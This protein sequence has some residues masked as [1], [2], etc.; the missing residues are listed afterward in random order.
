MP[1]KPLTASELVAL[2][3][4]AVE[5]RYDVILRLL[6]RH[7][8][9]QLRLY[10]TRS[11]NPIVAF[12]DGVVPAS[13]VLSCDLTLENTRTQETLVRM[14][15]ASA[16]RVQVVEPLGLFMVS[17]GE[18]TLSSYAGSSVQQARLLDK[19]LA[20]VLADA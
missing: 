7:R 2:A 6:A 19:L 16:V 17:I 13:I 10:V 9:A 20:P 8:T 4:R 1:R 3:R 12:A 18:R 15:L 11:G 14:L 5:Q